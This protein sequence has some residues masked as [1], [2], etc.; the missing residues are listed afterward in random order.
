MSRIF[1][2]KKA[3]FIVILVLAILIALYFLVWYIYYCKDIKPLLE[4]TEKYRTITDQGYTIRNDTF[5]NDTLGGIITLATPPVG[6]FSGNLSI[7]QATI[8]DDNHNILNPYSVDITI[9]LKFNKTIKV[10]I[11]NTA[12]SP[13]VDYS[14]NAEDIYEVDKNMNIIDKDNH[15]QESLK[16]YETNRDVINELRA[17]LV[18]RFGE[19]NLFE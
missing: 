18:R 12:T 4:K 5:H 6:K 8:L 10:T 16:L 7:L 3:I 15:T 14:I 1:Q 11:Y 9:F 13:T 2:K 19:D 17:E